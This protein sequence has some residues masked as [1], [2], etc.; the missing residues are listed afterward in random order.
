MEVSVPTRP[1]VSGAS[2]PGICVY[3]VL[4]HR[5]GAIL[6]TMDVRFADALAG[7]EHGDTVWLHWQPLC[8]NE[9]KPTPSYFIGKW[10]GKWRTGAV[11]ANVVRRQW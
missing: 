7:T 3:V 4:A 10:P 11:A 2:A 9:H 1:L 8:W 5:I 6:V